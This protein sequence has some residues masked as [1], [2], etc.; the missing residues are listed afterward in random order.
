MKLISLYLKK[1]LHSH[2]SCYE[3]T[4][5]DLFGHCWCRWKWIVFTTKA[6]SLVIG[7]L[8]CCFFFCQK[9]SSLSREY[10][11]ICWRNLTYRILRESTDCKILFSF[12]SNYW[13]TYISPLLC[14]VTCVGRLIGI[15]FPLSHCHLLS[16]LSGNQSVCVSVSLLHIFWW[17]ASLELFCLRNFL[18]LSGE[19]LE[20]YSRE[21][22][23]AF[24]NVLG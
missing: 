10:L 8:H 1:S 24:G 2:A 13:I 14:C 19:Y 15:T 21:L 20:M 22:S 4:V 7:L 3:M 17:P 11:E 6:A 23:A 9:I 5:I 16:A 18:I 12:Y